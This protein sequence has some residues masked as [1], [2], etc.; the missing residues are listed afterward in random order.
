MCLA[1][2]FSQA[3]PDSVPLAV[4]L[5]KGTS[6]ALMLSAPQNMHGVFCFLYVTHSWHSRMSVVLHVWHGMGI[7]K[8]KCGGLVF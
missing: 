2:H 5:E 6:L 1:R 8:E 3:M 4:A 7:M